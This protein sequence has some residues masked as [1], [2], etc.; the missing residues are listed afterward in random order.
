D[1]CRQVAGDLT[2]EMSGA[3][4]GVDLAAHVKSDPLGTGGDDTDIV[5]PGIGIER[6]LDQFTERPG[7]Q[8]QVEIT[9]SSL[10]NGGQNALGTELSG[11]DD[12]SRGTYR[13]NAA[14]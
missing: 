7:S 1:L 13:T 4:G 3:I 14:K 2:Q 8:G 12:F 5:L 11:E 9:V 6:L 10:A